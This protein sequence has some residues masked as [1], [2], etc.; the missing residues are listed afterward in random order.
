MESSKVFL[1]IFAAAISGGVG[2]PYGAIAGGFLVGFAETLSVFNWALLLRP[3]ER[4]SGGLIE[5]PARLSFVAAEYK[6]TVPFVILV[7]VLVFRPT[8]IFRGKVL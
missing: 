2:Q 4:L 3:L 5:I 7:L 1:P 6:L 8:G